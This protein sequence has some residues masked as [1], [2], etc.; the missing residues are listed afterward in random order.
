MWIQRIEALRQVSRFSFINVIKGQCVS[1]QISNHRSLAIEKRYM[2]N[3][4]SN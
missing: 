2:L 4:A 3:A 1:R